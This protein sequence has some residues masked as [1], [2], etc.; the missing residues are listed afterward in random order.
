MRE[1]EGILTP[2]DR[3]LY[4]TGLYGARQRFR[5][6][7]ALLI[8]DVTRSFVGSRPMPILEAVQEY[9]TSCGERGWEALPR[10]RTLLDAGRRAGVPIIYTRP[11]DSLRSF[12]SST[13][14]I[15]NPEAQR[16]YDDHAQ[17]IPEI[18]APR[19]NDLVIDKTKASGF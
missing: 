7:P 1:W 10:I 19:P 2:A 5:S 4:Q 8:V 13:T 14:K 9:A 16:T 17:D 3:E 12:A 6:H 15:E 11:D 18:I